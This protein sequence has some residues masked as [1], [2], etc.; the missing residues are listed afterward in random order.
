MALRARA[1][2]MAAPSLREP[3]SVLKFDARGVFMG[4]F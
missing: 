1:A 3:E 2:S 4:F